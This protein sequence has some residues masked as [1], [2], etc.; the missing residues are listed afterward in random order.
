M[1][2]DFVSAD[3]GW[4]RSPD[5][6][7][8]ARV[9][10]RPGA[11]QDGYFTND[12]IIMQATKV[13]DILKEYYPDDDHIFVYDS[14]TTHLK[15]ARDSISA[16]RMPMKTSKPD[17]NWLVATPSLDDSGHQIFTSKGEKITKSIQMAPGRFNDGTPQSF[18]FPPGHWHAGLFKGMR[19]ILEE[20]GFPASSFE[21]FKRECKNFHCPAGQTDCCMRRRLY[22]QPDFQNVKSVLEDRC[23]QKGVEVFFL[24]KFHPE[25]NPIEQ[26]WGRAKWYY[27]KLPASSLEADLE[28]NVV[29]SLES[30]PLTLM[31]R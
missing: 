9:L 23:N 13:M 21:N 7:T 27:R 4:L 2:A 5:G 1:V 8:S 14:A 6:E 22:S 24:P 16:R 18:Y 15:R 31:R 29:E 30:I 3:Y 26:C 10:I 25:L 20:R 17:K 19:I 11:Q 28:R 12:D